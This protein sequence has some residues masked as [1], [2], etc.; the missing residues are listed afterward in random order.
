MGRKLTLRACQ[1][2][3][4]MCHN[5]KILWTS[6][7]SEIVSLTRW[8]QLSLHIKML[9]SAFFRFV[10]S[11]IIYPHYT[12]RVNTLVNS[13]R[14]LPIPDRRRLFLYWIRLRTFLMQ[15]RRNKS[16]GLSHKIKTVIELIFFYTVLIEQKTKI[17]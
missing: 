9:I 2:S 8:N 14:L 1:T 5:S 3:I 10:A 16:D 6:L 13:S 17:I 4:E 15:H 7:Y 12:L 11:A